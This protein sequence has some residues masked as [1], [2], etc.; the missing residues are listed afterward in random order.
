MTDPDTANLQPEAVLVAGVRPVS[1]ANWPETCV[2]FS[3]THH[4]W[5]VRVLKLSTAAANAGWLLVAGFSVLPL[6]VV[7][8]AKLAVA[9]RRR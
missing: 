9:A 1:S 8:A 3:R 4:G 2:D 7:Q 5:L 6:A